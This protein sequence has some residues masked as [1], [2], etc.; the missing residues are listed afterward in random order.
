MDTYQFIIMMISY[1]LT[2]FVGYKFGRK[3]QKW[4]TNQKKF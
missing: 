3:V 1:G 2:F 4:E